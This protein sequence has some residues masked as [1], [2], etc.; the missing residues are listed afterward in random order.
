[1]NDLRLRLLPAALRRCRKSARWNASSIRILWRRLR[2]GHCRRRIDATRGRFDGRVQ[3]ANS[4]PAN[5]R[6]IFAHDQYGNW[7]GGGGYTIRQGFR[8]GASAYRGPYLSRD[9]PYF[10]PGEA[11]PNTLP[12]HA[13]GLDV[14][15]ARGHWN[16]QGEWQ[17]FVMPYAAIPT[18]REQAGYAEIKR[19]LAPHWYAAARMGYTSASF[20]GLSE[21]FETA[22]GYRP[23]RNELI[24]MDYEFDHTGSGANPTN[25]TLAIQFVAT[26][27][28]SHAE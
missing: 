19:A 26:L 1:M 4:S 6:S 12:A 21:R 22:A 20:G 14:A 9:S 18:F 13:F 27:H 8:I 28:A 15:W 24:K 23:G 16:S 3:F 2:P 5:P 25:H 17:K 10:F 11:N 7:A